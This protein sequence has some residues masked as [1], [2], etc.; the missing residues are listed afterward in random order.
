MSK[1]VNSGTR[2]GQAVPASYKTPAV[3]L[4]YKF[5]SGKSIGTDRGRKTS[6]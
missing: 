6:T 2:K 5:K 1:K 4:L 3:L